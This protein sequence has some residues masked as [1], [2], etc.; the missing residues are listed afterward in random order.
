[1][2]TSFYSLWIF[3]ITIQAFVQYGQTQSMQDDGLDPL[4]MDQARLN[5][6]NEDYPEPII[7]KHN[8]VVCESCTYDL[9]AGPLAKNTSNLT[10]VDT[11]HAHQFQLFI[12]SSNR[13]IQCKE[14][15]YDFREYGFYSFKIMGT[16]PDNISCLITPQEAEPDAI[17]YWL[18]VL[19]GFGTF[20]IIILIIQLW[21]CVSRRPGYIRWCP[22]AVQ[23]EAI[24]YDF[25]IPPPRSPD[26]ITNDSADD[27]VGTLL[28]GNALTLTGTSSR[29][30]IIPK[31]K[32]EF[33]PKRLRS[34]DAFRGFSLMIMIFVNY[35]GM[36]CLK[37]FRSFQPFDSF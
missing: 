5:I 10:F 12:S 23:S 18:P 13:T 25:S 15:S 16:S 19:V 36:I 30:P 35:G 31:P 3:L 6:T 9:L 1:M 24:I 33:T 7:V 29:A 4:S 27:I 28:G 37:T 2:K 11:R 34:L 17:Y 8:L 22:K 20:F 21:R 14:N 26:L 32:P